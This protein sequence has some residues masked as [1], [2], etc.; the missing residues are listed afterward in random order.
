MFGGHERPIGFLSTSYYTSLVV[1]SQCIDK[2]NEKNKANNYTGILHLVLHT[3]KRELMTFPSRWQAEYYLHMIP[4]MQVDGNKEALRI[5]KATLSTMM[6]V[7]A[8]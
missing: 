6:W 4:I 2:A 1:C 3:G 5:H 7:E 8:T